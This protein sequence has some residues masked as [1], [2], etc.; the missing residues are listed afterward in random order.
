[1]SGNLL[2]VYVVELRRGRRQPAEE[3]PEAVPL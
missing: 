3:E 2:N 1:M